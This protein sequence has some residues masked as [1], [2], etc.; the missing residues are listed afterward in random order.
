MGFPHSFFR[1]NKG[2]F[3][4]VVQ[5]SSYFNPSGVVT[6]GLRKLDSGL[7]HGAQDWSY[8]G[9][10]K[11]E[12]FAYNTGGGTNAAIVAKTS[13]ADEMMLAVHQTTGFTF[14]IWSSL[15]PVSISSTVSPST[16]V[17]YNC[18][19]EYDNSSGD[20]GMSIQN[21]ALV[22][23][24]SS[25]SDTEASYLKFNQWLASDG[26][27]RAKYSQWGRWNRKLT[28]A[29]RLILNGD[30]KGKL[31]ATLPPAL[32]SGLLAYWNMDE[33]D[34]FGVATSR[35]DSHGTYDMEE[36]GSGAKGEASSD[37]PN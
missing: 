21:E 16:G 6:T 32:L 35:I 5:Q 1:R 19:I 7:Q 4:P 22:Q 28:P 34:T 37:V 24:A 9:W 29:E 8:F 20:M 15:S 13:G 2:I 30:G 33:D 14:S 25:A 10:V 26:E 36:I 3:V 11:F 31:H 18:Y 12:D 23:A 17:W 27:S